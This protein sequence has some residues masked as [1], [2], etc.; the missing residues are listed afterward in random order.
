MLLVLLRHGPYRPKEKDPEEGLSPEGEEIIATSAR[1]LARLGLRPSVVMASP[2]T[3]ARQSAAIA[4]RE[5]GLDPQ[6]VVVSEALKALARPED[7]LAAIQEAAGQ[8][9][10]LLAGH[11]P[12][13]ALVAAWLA[14][15]VA[16][17]GIELEAGGVAC[18]EAEALA[19]GR[20]ELL[21]LMQPTQLAALV[22]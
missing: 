14:L 15:G 21:W 17:T 3:R 9:P 7:S 22:G 19:P 13:L 20:G 10:V 16:E 12:N 11:L 6:G 8:G 5:L 18:L 1:A 2:K 4:A